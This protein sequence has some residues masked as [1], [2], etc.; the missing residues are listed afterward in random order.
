M[1]EA[2][3]S[4][5]PPSCKRSHLFRPLFALENPK[6]V[7]KGGHKHDKPRSQCPDEQL[8]GDRRGCS[9]VDSEIRRDQIGKLAQR[10]SPKNERHLRGSADPGDPV[11]APPEGG[12]CD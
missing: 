8:K 11:P 3:T 2:A 5:T 6:E 12:Q 10:P 4:S 7:A 1:V 9:R